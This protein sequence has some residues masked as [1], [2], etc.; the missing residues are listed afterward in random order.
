MAFETGNIPKET[1]DYLAQKQAERDANARRGFK[2]IKWCFKAFALL[3]ATGIVLLM[4]LAIVA[5]FLPPVS[6]KGKN[7][8]SQTQAH[9]NDSPLNQPPYEPDKII[10]RAKRDFSNKNYDSALRVLGNLKINDLHRPE[11]Q[12]LY[13]SATDASL[14]Q[15]LAESRSARISYAG[16]YERALLQDGEDATVRAQGKNADTLSI[17]YV[18]INRP[19]V[20][21]LMNNQ[22]LNSR[23]IAL[24][25]K[26]VRLSD[27]YEKSWSY[28]PE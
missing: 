17:T 19:F 3:I 22:E 14:K 26:T 8:T 28:K 2:F 11:V 23:W 15:S 5:H 7:G 6:N 4:L 20:Y 1:L 25:F 13:N 16:D 18:L 27:G 10:A 24:G 21:Q 9:A 12:N